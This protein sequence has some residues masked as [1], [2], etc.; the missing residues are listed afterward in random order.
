MLMGI[1]NRAS[2]IGN[3][4]NSFK[5]P[6]LYAPCHCPLTAGA[7]P[8]GDAART[9]ERQSQIARLTRRQVA[10]RREP[11]HATGSA[12]RCLGNLPSPSPDAP[13]TGDAPASKIASLTPLRIDGT[14][15][16]ARGLTATHCLPYAPSPIT[17]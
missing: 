17:R 12:T 6:S 5:S 3:R 1:G 16:R 2:G 9:T 10:Q 14:G 11:P 4:I 13:R 15:N 8:V 7:S